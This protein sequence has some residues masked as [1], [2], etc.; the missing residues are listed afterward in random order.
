MIYDLE[1]RTSTD[2]L[3]G[4]TNAV[5]LSSGHLAYIASDSLWVIPFDVERRTA[6][7]P[8]VQVL[9]QMVTTG[10][11]AGDFAVSS[12]GTLVYAHAAGY[13]PFARTLSW[14]DRQGRRESLPSPPY[15]Y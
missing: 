8:A 2:L 12:N 6:F 10:N 3:P 11:G 7:G 13:D 1:N 5:Y 4:G 14:I 15:P 9:K